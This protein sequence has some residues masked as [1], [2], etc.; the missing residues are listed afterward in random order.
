MGDSD[1]SVMMTGVALFAEQFTLQVPPVHFTLKNEPASPLSL[2]SEGPLAG[3]G[4]S[5]YEG[6][7][8]SKI[9]SMISRLAFGDSTTLTPLIISSFELDYPDLC[10]L[11]LGS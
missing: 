5:T 9:M 3:I 1:P 4:S 6:W 8:L 7:Q 10:L 11:T 2:Y